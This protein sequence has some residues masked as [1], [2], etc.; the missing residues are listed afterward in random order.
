MKQLKMPIS[1]VLTVSV[2]S[3]ALYFVAPPWNTAFPDPLKIK[4]HNSKM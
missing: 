2:R 3:S 4:L 1:P